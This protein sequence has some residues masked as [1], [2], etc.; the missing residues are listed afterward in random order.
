VPRA[1]TG[2]RSGAVQD[3]LVLGSLLNIRVSGRNWA[4]PIH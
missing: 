3:P 1:G 2:I 4:Q